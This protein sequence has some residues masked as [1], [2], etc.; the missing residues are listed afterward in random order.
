[1]RITPLRGAGAT[2][3][4]CPAP[5][6]GLTCR[7]TALAA[8]GHCPGCGHDR[9]IRLDLARGGHGRVAAAPLHRQARA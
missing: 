1:M 3:L 5:A 9:L 2:L 6:C 4:K 8:Q 7:P